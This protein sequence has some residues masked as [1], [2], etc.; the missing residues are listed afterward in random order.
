MM[1]EHQIELASCLREFDYSRNFFAPPV[2]T[3]E[4]I[5]AIS[6]QRIEKFDQLKNLLLAYREHAQEL[7]AS[8]EALEKMVG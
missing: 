6:F 7:L 1:S 8:I 3:S 2:R 4:L 5:S